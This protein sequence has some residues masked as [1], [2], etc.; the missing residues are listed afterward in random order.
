VDG[1]GDPDLL[2]AN[3]N[4]NALLLND[5]TGVFAPAPDGALPL[6]AH[7][8]E[9][10]EADLADIDD[11][12]DLDA[13]FANVARLP[14]AV[15]QNRILLNDG[16]GRF[17][18]ATADLLP[19]ALSFSLDVDLVDIDGDGDLDRVGAEIDRKSVV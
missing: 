13:C 6:P 19:A 8:E 5:G 15:A 3:E 9:T 12:G 2:I 11:D 16:A 4:D 7:P 10:R 17:T 14:G 18:D 1:D